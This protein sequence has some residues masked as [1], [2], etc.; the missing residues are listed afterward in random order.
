MKER[1]QIACWKRAD[2]WCLSVLYKGI[3]LLHHQH[4]AAVQSHGLNKRQF[5]QRE[6]QTVQ[7]VPCADLER[8]LVMP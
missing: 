7:T 4:C 2:D 1:S 6:S 5:N 8:T 3:L